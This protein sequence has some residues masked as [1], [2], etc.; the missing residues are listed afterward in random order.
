[1]LTS[2]LRRGHSE[3]GLREL[4]GATLAVRGDVPGMRAFDKAHVSA[5]LRELTG[6]HRIVL[7]DAANLVQQPRRHEWVIVR[8]E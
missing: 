4:R 7:H 8:T 6:D 1:M 3:Q 2:E 5:S